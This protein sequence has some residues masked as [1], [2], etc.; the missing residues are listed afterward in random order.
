MGADRQSLSVRHRCGQ[1]LAADLFKGRSQ[2]LV[3]HFMFGPDYKAGC[4]SC[5]AIADGF[6]GIAV[7]L[8]EPRRDAVGRVARA[9]RE[10][11][12]LQAAAGMDVPLG[13]LGAAATSTPTSMSGSA[14]SSSARAMSNTITVASRRS[15]GVPA[16]KRRR[17]SGRQFAASCGT[18]TPTYHRDRPG[19]SAFVIE[20]GAIYHTY[21]TYSRGWTACGACTSGSTAPPRDATRPAASGFAATTSTRDEG[22]HG[23]PS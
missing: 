9:A 19:L 4:P 23:D 22:R 11:A 15:S 20:D 8:A 3:Y 10:A 1:R 6:N 14:R 7:H 18:D 21:S 5:S 17:R 12:G 13:V 16:R 2:L